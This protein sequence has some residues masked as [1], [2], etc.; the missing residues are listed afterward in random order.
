MAGTVSKKR[1]D[2]K[3]TKPTTR[4]ASSK[5]SASAKRKSGGKRSA[6]A[7]PRKA[8]RRR[9]SKSAAAR[10]YHPGPPLVDE[11]TLAAA[12]TDLEALDPVTVGA[13][14]AIGGPPK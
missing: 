10:L 2:G 5:R 1:G 8:I 13:M 12:L 6:T 7:K 3:R 9:A 4:S 11:P 14:L